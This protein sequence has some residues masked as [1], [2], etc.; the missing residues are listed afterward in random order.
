MGYQVRAHTDAEYDDVVRELRRDR[1]AIVLEAP[2]RKFVAVDDDLS[3]ELLD[4]IA[5]LGGDVVPDVQYELEAE[6]G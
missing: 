1:V 5:H 2:H 4:R 6:P 3:P